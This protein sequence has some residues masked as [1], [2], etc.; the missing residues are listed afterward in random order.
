[1]NTSTSSTLRIASYNIRKAVGTDRR[2]D[3]HRILGII[4]DL[5]ADIV[6]LQEAD[7][8][9]G[10]RPSVLPIKD[11][12]EQTGL[13]PIRLSTDGPS[14]GWHGNSILMRPSVKIAGLCRFDLPGM[15][16]R[17]AVIADLIVNETLL[18]V[19]AVHLGLLRS[20]RRRQLSSLIEKLG[21]LDGTPTL[22]AG[23][24]NEWS[25]RVGLGRIAHHFTIHAPGNSFH[26]NIP[27][28]AL[29][30]IALDQ[31]LE[32]RGAGV[33][34]TPITRCA[35]DHLPIWMDIGVKN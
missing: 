27:L 9:F 30:R 13:V 12:E 7:R 24:L 25:L 15:E 6:V 31:Y 10:E 23:D 26:A 28:A 32:P 17:G 22:V 11:I 35:S 34:D 14:L 33:L 16:P 5:K 2:R 18:R 1:M 21:S 8:R 20:S 4:A 19:I 29:D 3:P